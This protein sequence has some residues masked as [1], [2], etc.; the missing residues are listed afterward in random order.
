M[1][2]KAGQ[3][4]E[5]EESRARQQEEKTP[6]REEEKK[7]AC[8]GRGHRVVE[9][10]WRSSFSPGCE[11]RKGEMTLSLRGRTTVV[12]LGKNLHQ[13]M[14]E[15]MEKRGEETGDVKWNVSVKTRESH[16]GK[17]ETVKKK[18]TKRDK[19][20][21][22]QKRRSKEEEMKGIDTKHF[23]LMSFPSTIFKGLGIGKMTHR[24][25]D[26]MDIVA[27]TH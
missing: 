16:V 12:H 10:E 22:D 1:A 11:L 27:D 7:P 2:W 26:S 15:K 20:K 19:V 17:D 4:K 25:E 24:F 23:W 8:H 21:K 14:C 3:G 18:K 5:E 9:Q 6:V 13:R